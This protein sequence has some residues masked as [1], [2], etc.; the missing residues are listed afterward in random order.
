MTNSR[1]GWFHFSARS[2]FA[3]VSAIALAAAVVFLALSLASPGRARAETLNEYFSVAAGMNH[4]PPARKFALI[5]PR[6]RVAAADRRA[7]GS[8]LASWYGGGERLARHTASGAVFRPNGLSAA[9]RTLPLGTRIRVSLGRRSVVV[10]V[11]DRGPAAWTGRSL[12]LSRG[13]ASAL[14]FLGAGVARVTYAVE[15]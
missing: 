13:A 1:A 14:G 9:H 11:N 2:F 4:P 8:T 15:G 3:A 6:G 7:N 5:R 10:V 12:D